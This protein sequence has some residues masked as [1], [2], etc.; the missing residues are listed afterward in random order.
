MNKL[1]DRIDR[2]CARHPRWGIPNLMRYVVIGTAAMYILYLLT[3]QSPELYLLTSLSPYAVLRGQVWRLITFI[4]LPMTA[5]PLL[6]VL[7]LYFYYWMGS[8]LENYWGTPKFTIY[9]LSGIVLSILGAF[10]AYF[11]GSFP[12][13]AGLHYVNMAM[14]LAYAALAPD[15]VVLLF[16]FLPIKIKWLAWVDLAYFAYEVLSS[17]GYRDWGSALM[18]VV[19]LLNFAVFFWPYFSKRARVQRSARSRQATRFRQTVKASQRPR[20][21]THKCCVC[22]KTDAD[23]PNMAF[24]YCSRCA[25]YHCFCEEHIFNHVHFTEEDEKK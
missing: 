23:Y 19:A 7:S 1:Y 18:P 2:F 20:G 16:F 9:Y 12:V 6:L 4:F 10:I 22:G 25:G 11:L 8:I 24:R 15:A 14:F 3:G 17:V 13:I 21:Y 5:S